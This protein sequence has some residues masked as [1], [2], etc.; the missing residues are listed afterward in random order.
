MAFWTAD[1]IVNPD[2]AGA[3]FANFYGLGDLG[4][5]ALAVIG[6]VQAIFVVA[7]AIGA[8]K[9]I[10]YGAILLMHAV[11]TL[12]SW[13]QYLEPFENLLFFAA[14]PML[15]GCVALFLLRDHDRLLAVDSLRARPQ[16]SGD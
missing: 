1:K 8:F 7:F 5:S 3:V 9:T 15:A 12:S 13:R 2:H 6:V 16:P 14:W 11:S 4:S 10:S